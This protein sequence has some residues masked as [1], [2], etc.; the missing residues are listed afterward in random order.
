[1]ASNVLK[2]PP[3]GGFFA[4]VDFTVYPMTSPAS[5]L[6]I[7]MYSSWGCVAEKKKSISLFRKE[8]GAL[9]DQG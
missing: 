7:F 2:K 6:K 8:F 4:V 3:E 9:G 5:Y 1:V